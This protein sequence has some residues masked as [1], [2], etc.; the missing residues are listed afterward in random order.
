MTPDK[1]DPDKIDTVEKA[2]NLS[3]LKWGGVRESATQLFT[4]IDTRCGF[5]LYAEQLTG[6]WAAC[7]KCPV[8]EKCK[9][10]NATSSNIEATLIRLIDN[11]LNFLREMKTDA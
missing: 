5:C 6:N 4:D 8:Q 3:L 10:I 7:Y 9:E 1:K 11:I 2:R